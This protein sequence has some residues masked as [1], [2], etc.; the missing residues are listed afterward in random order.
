M[1]RKWWGH[2]WSWNFICRKKGGGN[3]DVSRVL[4]KIMLF[5]LVLWKSI[6]TVLSTY[7]PQTCLDNSVK[8]LFY[9]NLQLTLTKISA[10]EILFVCRDFNGHIGKN[11]EGYELPNGGRELGRRNL[12]GE[13][14][15][16]CC[17]PQPS[18]FKFTFHEKGESPGNM[19]ILWKSASNW[20]H[21]SQEYQISAWCESHPK[22]RVCN[23]TQTICL[24]RKN[25][26]KWRS[27]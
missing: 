21:L 12:E 19:L 26:K 23:V 16:S 22:W 6:V 4:D 1:G 8:D 25:C 17:R 24:W 11:E 18:C 9:E 13:D 5:K 2:W 3:F 10:S 20:L 27:A 7:V 14:C 15:W